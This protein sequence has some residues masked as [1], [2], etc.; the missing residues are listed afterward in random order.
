MDLGPTDSGS[1]QASTFAAG[2]DESGSSKFTERGFG[3]CLPWSYLDFFLVS[4]N[5]LAER[6]SDSGWFANLGSCRTSVATAAQIE[7]NVQG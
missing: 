3:N 5:M 6:A 7:T 1:R 4:E 2:C